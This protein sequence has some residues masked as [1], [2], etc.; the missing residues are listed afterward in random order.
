MVARVAKATTAK[1]TAGTM[2]RPTAKTTKI[3][4]YVIIAVWCVWMLLAAGPDD[5]L[6]WCSAAG[7][8]LGIVNWRDL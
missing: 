7:V 5:V 4:S 3:V 1:A 6:I 2:D 8:A